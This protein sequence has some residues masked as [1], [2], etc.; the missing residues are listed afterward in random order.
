[1]AIV[2]TVLKKTTNEVVI[3]LTGA[4]ADTTTLDLDGTDFVSAAEAAGTAGTQLVN[5]AGIQWTGAA[6]SVCTITRN[7]VTI[8]TLQA[9]AAGFLD[10]TGQDMIPDSQQNDQNITVTFTTAAGEVWLKLHKVAGYNLKV[11][12]ATFG[13]Y[14]NT[15]NVGS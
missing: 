12:P 2:K 8:A 15:S 13:I 6:G 14:D 3:K 11:E 5:I 7:S 9:N 10:M 4:A 1:M